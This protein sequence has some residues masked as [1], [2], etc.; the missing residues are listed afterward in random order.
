[1][2]LTNYRSHNLTGE[3]PPVFP[4]IT[5]PTRITFHCA[6]VVDKTFRSSLNLISELLFTGVSGSSRNFVIHYEQKESASKANAR[7]RA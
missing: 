2:N 1:M 4:L 6:A 3:F 5:R 7:G